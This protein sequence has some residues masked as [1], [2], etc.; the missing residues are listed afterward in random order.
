MWHGLNNA[1]ELQKK[2]FA[3]IAATLQIC[4]K[5]LEKH[6]QTGVRWYVHVSLCGKNESWLNSRR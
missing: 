4:K 3:N 1:A 5:N 2:G 6:I